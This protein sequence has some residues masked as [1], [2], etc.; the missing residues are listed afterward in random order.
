M[1]KAIVKLKICRN[2]IQSFKRAE[3]EKRQNPYHLEK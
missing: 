3:E 2:F 1:T